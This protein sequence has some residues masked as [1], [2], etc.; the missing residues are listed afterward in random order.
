MAIPTRPLADFILIQPDFALGGCKAVFD[1]PAQ[2]GD[3]DQFGKRC[4][5]R[6]EDAI[7]G[8][9]G[10]VRQ[11]PTSQKPATPSVCNRLIQ[12]DTYPLIQPWPFGAIAS[13]QPLPCRWRKTTYDF[14]DCD[15]PDE[16]VA[17][18]TDILVP[19]N[20]E[21]IGLLLCFQPRT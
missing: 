13:T 3:T 17:N 21:H 5:G 14:V 9:L 11:V 1:R 4:V 7:I 8:H 15:R 19:P 12:L 16:S 18:Q 20:R 6:C 10:R 2:T